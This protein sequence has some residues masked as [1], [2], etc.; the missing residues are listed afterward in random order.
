MGSQYQGLR[1]VD[2]TDVW[3]GPMAAT[4]LADLGADVIRVESFPRPGILRPVEAAPGMPGFIDNDPT[5]PPVWERQVRNYTP[6]RNK[7]GIALNLK[8]PAGRE[9]LDRL[10]RDADVFLESFASG[11]VE[12]LGFGWK[13]LT[14]LNPRLIM[15]SLS[16]WGHG[17]PFH[18]FRSMGSGIDSTTGHVHVRRYRDTDPMQ[19]PQAYQSDAAAA[20]AAFFAVGVALR[21]RKRT[22][23]GSWIDMAQAEVLMAQMPTPFLEAQFGVSSEPL[24]NRHPAHVP[25]NCYPCAG[26]DAWIQVCV[27]SQEQWRSLCHVL[28]GD[29]DADPEFETPMARRKHR[30]RL[31]VEI[32]ALTVQHDHRDLMRALQEAGVP[33]GAVYRNEELLEDE[34]LLARGFFQE[35][36]HPI[37][38]RR[39]Y[40]G[41]AWRIDHI[42][43]TTLRPTNLLGEHN[44]EVLAELGY[45]RA[46]IDDM[47]R[48]GVVGNTFEFLATEAG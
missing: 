27:E 24:E 43:G 16:A 48:R 7:R 4:F 17:G 34:Q 38:G 25:F 36:E 5:A 42:Y 41:Q 8:E 12:K 46:Q 29:L 31:D 18:G 13:R 14:E 44:A 32:A 19:T 45:G 22:G 30:A 11:V 15:V 47:T 37:A 39:T 21:Q 23:T 33:A 2:L 1:V 20:S 9:V 26:E 40:P 6:N 3:A 10:L 28:A 35:W